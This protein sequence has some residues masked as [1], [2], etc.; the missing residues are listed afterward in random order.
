MCSIVIVSHQ[1]A[2][3][4]NHYFQRGHS[5]SQFLIPQVFLSFPNFLSL[6]NISLSS[7]HSVSTVGLC[8]YF[9]KWSYFLTKFCQLVSI[10][11]T[12]DINSEP[13]AEIILPPWNRLIR[14]VFPYIH[15]SLIWGSFWPRLDASGRALWVWL[16]KGKWHFVLLEKYPSI[17]PI[18]AE[19]AF[20]QLEN[21]TSAT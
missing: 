19:T 8:T 7:L 12:N 14:F 20:Q 18:L 13:I 16:W 3:Q 11:N 2:D 1:I 9:R 4:Y 10:F 15:I 17:C 21:I 6:P 5:L